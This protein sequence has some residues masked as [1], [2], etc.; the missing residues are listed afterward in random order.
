MKVGYSSPL[1]GAG[2]EEEEEDWEMEQEEAISAGDLDGAG[3]D[4]G[5]LDLGL[6]IAEAKLG[7]GRQV[8]GCVGFLL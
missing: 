8:G 3:E 4:L 2:A 5:S 7:F 1:Q 6:G